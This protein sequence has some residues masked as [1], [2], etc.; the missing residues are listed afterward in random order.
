MAMFTFHPM[1]FLCRVEGAR[2]CHCR[3]FLKN[4][5]VDNVT[6]GDLLAAWQLATAGGAGV[7]CLH[8]LQ[9]IITLFTATV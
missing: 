3:S 4:C 6:V 7:S 1:P 5:G 9:V 2:Q 8:S